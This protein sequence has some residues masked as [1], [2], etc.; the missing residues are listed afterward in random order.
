VIWLA[1]NAG[2]R[3][4]FNQ[5][6]RW[7]TGR[8]PAAAVTQNTTPQTEGQKM[9]ESAEE[10]V[11]RL[12]TDVREAEENYSLMCQ[13]AQAAVNN[14]AKG[15]LAQVA[16]LF[17]LAATARLRAGLAIARLEAAKLNFSAA[18][19]LMAAA[20]DAQ[21][22]ALECD[23]MASSAYGKARRVVSSSH[24]STTLIELQEVLEKER[25]VAFYTRQGQLAAEDAE[26]A[27]TRCLNYA[28]WAAAAPA[29]GKAAA[30]S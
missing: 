3:I 5:L 13:R 6:G 8:V 17:V 7:T 23:Q 14:A 2:E 1:V 29:E 28:A 26:Q 21:V 20:V 11:E 16:A 18:S 4:F 12:K 19:P 30:Q 27:V 10:R 22:L 9:A 15:I 25:A 24:T